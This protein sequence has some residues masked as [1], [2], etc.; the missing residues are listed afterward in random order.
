MMSVSVSKSR[1]SRRAVSDARTRGLATQSK[2]RN[3]S[4]TAQVPT[5]ATPTALNGTSVRP[6]RRCSSFQVVGP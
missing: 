2:A 5:L 6:C 3:S 1:P 4:G